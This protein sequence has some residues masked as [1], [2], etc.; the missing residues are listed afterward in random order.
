MS[1]AI[2]F[3][4]LKDKILSGKKK[5]TIRP[6]NPDTNY[7]LRFKKGDKLIGFWQMRQGGEKLFDSEFSE[8]PFIVKWKDFTHSLMI[9]DGFRNL[10]DANENWFLDHYG[11]ESG[12]LPY[13]EFVVIR[14]K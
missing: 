4:T 7:W 5:Q 11:D 1:P 10:T 9:R 6:N 3:S 14:W 12:W 13:K 8:D 2:S